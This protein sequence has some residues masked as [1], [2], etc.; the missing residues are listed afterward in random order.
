YACS[1]WKVLLASRGSSILGREISADPF[2]MLGCDLLHLDLIVTLPGINVIK[3]TLA[4]RSAIRRDARVER[5]RDSQRGRVNRELQSQFVET[6]PL[7]SLI[8]CAVSGHCGVRSALRK[9]KH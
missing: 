7:Q 5:F 1:N 2:Q 3:L 9:K 6:C 4:A 8:D